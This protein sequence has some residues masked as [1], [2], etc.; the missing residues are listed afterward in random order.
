MQLNSRG[1]G[2]QAFDQC[3][4]H[5]ALAVDRRRRVGEDEETH[6]GLGM[7]GGDGKSRGE[8]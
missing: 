2:R 8:T 6:L 1:D 3:P 4:H 5:Q 7:C